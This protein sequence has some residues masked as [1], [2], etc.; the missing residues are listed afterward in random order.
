MK[1]HNENASP[2]IAVYV[3]DAVRQ[4]ENTYPTIR[5]SDWN[6]VGLPA[7][8]ILGSWALSKPGVERIV[9]NE[10]EQ[11]ALGVLPGD[12]ARSW[13]RMEGGGPVKRRKEQDGCYPTPLLA[14]PGYWGDCVY[15]DIKAAYRSMIERVGWDVDYKRGKYVKRNRVTMPD[16]T[17]KLVYATIV[18]MSKSRLSDLRVWD[19][20]AIGRKTIK[21]VYANPSLWAV[22]HDA[23][24]GVYGDL[25]DRSCLVYANTDGFVVPTNQL[26]DALD[27]INC[28]GFSARAKAQGETIIHGVGSYRVGSKQSRRSVDNRAIQTEAM[29][30]VERPFL[31]RALTW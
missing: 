6:L 2:D 7:G 21:N 19:G 11:V 30:A 10:K 1:S 3:R 20:R 31:R 12:V 24:A 15:I 25:L 13:V 27:I 18:S 17:P 14:L 8:Y 16:N 23:L 28:W 4:V 29:P 22:I 5:Y 9:T 26:D